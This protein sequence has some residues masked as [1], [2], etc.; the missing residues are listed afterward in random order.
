MNT[1]SAPRSLWLPVALAVAALAWRVA[2]LK[3]GMADV[4]PNFAPWMALAF[5]GS[6]VMPRSLPWWLWPSLLIGC[7]LAIGTGQ[8]QFMWLVY[9]CYGM[10]AIVGSHLRG[11]VGFLKTLLGTAVGS[12]A[13]YL[14]TNTQAWF[15][16]PAY[17]QSLAGWW[18]AQTVGDLVHQ[19]QAWVFLVRSLVSD[20]GFA[21]MLVI[22]CMS[23][24]AFRRTS[25]SAP[26]Q[27]AA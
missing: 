27:A 9:A 5:A 2:K 16:S 11:N 10:A 8:I 14:I 4:I 19:P 1:A 7:D 23:E 18:Q 20:L 22:A 17:A 24:S 26:A 6:I 12:V 3:F 15:H 13:F 21:S 25:Q